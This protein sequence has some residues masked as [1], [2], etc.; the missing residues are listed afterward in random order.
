MAVELRNRLSGRIGTRLPT[1]VAFDYPTARAM[2]RLLMEKLE[3][4]N[5]KSVPLVW[6]EEQIRSKLQVISIQSLRDS[7]LVEHI[8][9][10]PNALSFSERG[11]D[12]DPERIVNADAESL[13]EIANELL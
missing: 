1:T 11:M 10:Q 13:L 8:M 9:M 5:V 12:V 3:F 2:A 4:E 7:G 6:S